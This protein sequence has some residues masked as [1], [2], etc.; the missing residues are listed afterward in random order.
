MFIYLG[1]ITSE[2]AALTAKLKANAKERY[3][4]ASRS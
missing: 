4:K 3:R 2:L 1:S